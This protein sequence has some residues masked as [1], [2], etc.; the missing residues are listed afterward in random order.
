VQSAFTEVPRAVVH[1]CSMTSRLPLYPF[2]NQEGSA[3][4][5]HQPT[6]AACGITATKT[7]PAE[8]EWGDAADCAGKFAGSNPTTHAT[9]KN[10]ARAA[11]HIGRDNLLLHSRWPDRNSENRLLTD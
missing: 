7:V 1:R 11:K 4:K 6:C 2:A 10:A 3:G 9:D 8:E 5:T